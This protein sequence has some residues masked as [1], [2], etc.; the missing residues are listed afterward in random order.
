MLSTLASTSRSSTSSTSSSAASS[1]SQRSTS[2]K[3]FTTLSTTRTTTTTSSTTTQTE[4]T[5]LQTTT[6]TTSTNL[7]L[8]TSQGCQAKLEFGESSPNV[9][10]GVTKFCEEVC[11]LKCLHLID[12]YER[13]LYLNSESQPTPDLL[14]CLDT[15]N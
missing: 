11:H 7:A 15:C 1:T 4:S 10:A 6:S 12:E 3:S 5:T 9:K 2:T 13:D 14:T 8:I